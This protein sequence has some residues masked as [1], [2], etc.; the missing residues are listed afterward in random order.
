MTDRIELA[1]LKVAKELA[2]FVSREALPGTGVGET[3][4]WE[5]F[6][7]IVHDLAPRNRALLRKRDEIQEKIDAWHRANGAP[8]DVAVYKDFLK[9]IA[10]R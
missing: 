9:D 6:S 5:S 10:M 7:A 3:A 8:S 1:G 4:F 2:D